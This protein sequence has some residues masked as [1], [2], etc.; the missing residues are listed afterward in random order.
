MKQT[1]AHGRDTAAHSSRG[2]YKGKSSQCRTRCACAC[3]AAVC[4]GRLSRC[5]R[6]ALERGSRVLNSEDEGL[7]MVG[8]YL[9]VQVRFA[10]PLRLYEVDPTST[11]PRHW[12][13]EVTPG[14]EMVRADHASRVR[15]LT[16]S[17][18]TLTTSPSEVP[19]SRSHLC[20]QNGAPRCR[21]QAELSGRV[22]GELARGQRNLPLRTLA[23][24]LTALRAPLLEN[25][26]DFG[27][28]CAQAYA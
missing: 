14:Y 1:P 24:R 13:A 20:V 17:S 27:V 26:S 5:L 12:A 18:A 6:F 7:W 10:T 9:Y 8:S 16:G 15:V 21:A 22:E 25:S 23:V 4:R 28:L 19:L 3:G 11:R 2:Q